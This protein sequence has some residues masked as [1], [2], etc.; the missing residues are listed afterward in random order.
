MYV[1]VSLLSQQSYNS[2]IIVLVEGFIN[3]GVNEKA[4]FVDRECY[5]ALFI[6]HELCRNKMV[7]YTLHYR[8]GIYLSV[9]I[10]I[11]KWALNKTLENINH[12]SDPHIL[13]IH[14]S[15]S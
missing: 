13:Q 12:M 10:Y 11:F 3:Q 2:L 1:N 8:Q 4:S 5:M 15:T 9:H 6:R 14:S 7:A